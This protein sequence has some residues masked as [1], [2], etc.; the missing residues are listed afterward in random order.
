[1]D[2]IERLNEHINRLLLEKEEWFAKATKCTS[3]FSDMPKG[4]GGEN[5]REDAI[6]K[7][8]DCERRANEL[9]DKLV[10]LK[11]ERSRS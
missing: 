4:G 3:S 10:E 9:I 5:P 7:M 6:C 1:M 2:E 11:K 8:M